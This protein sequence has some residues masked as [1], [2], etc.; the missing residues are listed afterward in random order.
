[1]KNR[2]YTIPIRIALIIGVIYFASQSSFF[3]LLGKD[4]EEGLDADSI[5]KIEAEAGTGAV[6]ETPKIVEAAPK[7]GLPVLLEEPTLYKDEFLLLLK[8]YNEA[9]FNMD[10]DVKF[11]DEIQSKKKVE[12]SLNWLMEKRKD[13]LEVP[14]ELTLAVR[15][16]INDNSK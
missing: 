5:I 10:L 16:Y 7:K 3:G 1:M 2:D 15:K 13:N 4:K 14:L 6:K 11:F 12:D 8:A 9:W